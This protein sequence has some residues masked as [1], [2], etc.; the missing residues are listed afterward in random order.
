MQQNERT[1]RKEPGMLGRIDFGNPSLAPVV[2]MLA[3]N[4]RRDAAA[5]SPPPGLRLSRRR[6]GE[7]DCAVLEP[8]TD[9]L[10]PGVLYC[11]GGGFFLPLQCA[12]LRI[13]EVFAKALRVRIV[14]PD[15]RL[16]PEHPAPAAFQ[17]CLEAWRSMQCDTGDRGLDGRV[18]LY[19][20]SAGGAL[21]A[22]LALYARDHSLPQASGQML[23][24]PALDDRAQPYPSRA[25]VTG[26]AWNASSNAAMWRG[27]L[28]TCEPGPYLV[29]L[30]AEN[31]ADLPPAYIEPQE[32]D[33]LRDEAAVFADKLRNAGVPVQCSEIP[34]SYH[35]FDDDTDHPFVRAALV[36]RIAA[37]NHMLSDAKQ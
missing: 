27:Y 3:G 31:F 6:I 1:E 21:A 8:D 32:L 33:I 16:L 19:G 13:A 28:R 29:P 22:G 17:D 4:L 25:G 11:H 34:G 37:M 5:W 2:R 35:G 18:I 23:I 9:E 36:R 30:R 26:A 12:A 7:A 14:M 15:Y 10:L 24:Y 20:E